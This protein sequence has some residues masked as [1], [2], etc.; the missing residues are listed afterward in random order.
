[1]TQSGNLGSMLKLL[2]LALGDLT[3]QG[4]VEEYDGAE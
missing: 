4:V 2:A 1:M 3:L